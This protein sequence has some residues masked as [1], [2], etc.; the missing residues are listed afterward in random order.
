[1][2]NK[3]EP[4]Y[5]IKQKSTNLFLH[6]FE[7]PDTCEDEVEFRDLQINARF[8]SVMG[9]SDDVF[10]DEYDACLISFSNKKDAVKYLEDIEDLEDV[11]PYDIEIVKLNLSANFEVV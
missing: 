9:L 3:I 5:L 7:D 1:M 11:N 8:T 2:T 10:N 4:I 6:I